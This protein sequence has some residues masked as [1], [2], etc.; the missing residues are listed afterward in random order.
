MKVPLAAGDFDPSGRQGCEVTQTREACAVFLRPDVRTLFL[1][2]SGHRVADP[3]DY[4][5]F[6]LDQGPPIGCL[7]ELYSEKH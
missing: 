3:I 2:A 1:A 4:V 6:K 5:I 7:P